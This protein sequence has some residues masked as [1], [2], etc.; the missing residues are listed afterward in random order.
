[1]A[2]TRPPRTPRQRT[3]SLEVE[4][5]I[6]DAAARIIGQEGTHAVTVRRLAAE[7]DVSPMSIYNRFGDMHGVFDAVLVRGFT[8]FA[9]AL[10]HGTDAR[11]PLSRL[12]DMGRAYRTFALDNRDLYSFMFLRSLDDIE[13]SADAAVAAARAFDAL[14]EAVQRLLESGVFRSGNASVVAQSI[15][16]TCH[17]AVALELLGMSDFADTDETYESLMTTLLR[18]LV[19]DPD[20]I[21][22]VGGRRPT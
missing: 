19:A 12:I 6:V 4:G 15:W 1:M 14:F 17:G 10:G 20:S 3:P 2:P 16:A 22:E 18:G 7:A 21:V 11:D 5:S 13:L 8:E 9:T